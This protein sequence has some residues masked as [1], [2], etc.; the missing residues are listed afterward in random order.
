M[1]EPKERGT[2]PL[3]DEGKELLVRCL[4]DVRRE[5]I[6]Q[7]QREAEYF[8]ADGDVPKRLIREHAIFN[9]FAELAWNG[10]AVKPHEPEFQARWHGIGE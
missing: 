7:A 4:A 8:Y 5:L 3:T 6:E 9:A 2:W 1:S 10:F